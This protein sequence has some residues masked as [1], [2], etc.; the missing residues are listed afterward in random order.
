MQLL[1]TPQVTKRL[2]RELRRAGGRE[3]GGLLLGEHVHDDVFRLVGIT[4]QR[5]GG[6]PASF[7]RNPNEHQRELAAFFERTGGDYTRFNY[8]GEWHSHP[9]MAPVPSST[10]MRSMQSIVEDPLV[11]ANFVILLVLS[12]VRNN[13]MTATALAFRPQARP[14]PVTIVAEP[15]QRLA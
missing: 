6:S 7:V 1:L 10:D 2:R 13:Q 11:G 5:T 14:V 12:M 8:L 15:S 9:R 4:V 3:I